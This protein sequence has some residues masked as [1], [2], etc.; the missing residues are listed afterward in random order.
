[1]KK[2]IKQALRAKTVDELQAEAGQLQGDM[3]KARLSTTLEGKRLGVRIR[4]SRRHIARINTLL[5]ERELA[6][7]PK[8]K[9]N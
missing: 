5:R 4:A 3:L 2:S 1:V 8:A 6:A 7:A 9:A